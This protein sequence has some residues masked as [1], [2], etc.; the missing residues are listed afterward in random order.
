MIHKI[1]VYEGN[2]VMELGL[3]NPCTRSDMLG[4]IDRLSTL[5]GNLRRVFI[6]LMV[7]PVVYAAVGNPG[8]I[9]LAVML[10]LIAAL[11]ALN[12]GGR[13]L[14]SL[15]KD[16][17]RCA[18]GMD[19]DRQYDHAMLQDV[20]AELRNSKK[21]TAAELLLKPATLA[22]PVLCGAVCTLLV[23]V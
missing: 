10:L 13:E 5:A 11:H 9:S 23:L 6:A 12:C 4:V 19:C 8:Y 18:E 7:V 14:V 2:V 20:F 1:P 21:P 17:R 22:L 3:P 16:A 15:F